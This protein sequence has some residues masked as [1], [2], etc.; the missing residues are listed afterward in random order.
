MRR[1]VGLLA[2][3]VFVPCI[4]GA[5]VTLDHCTPNPLDAMG[6]PQPMSVYGDGTFT[7]A[8]TETGGG[9]YFE[10]I[11][12]NTM[13]VLNQW[14]TSPNPTA[15]PP[16]PYSWMCAVI[17]GCPAGTWRFR[18][19]LFVITGSGRQGNVYSDLQ[20]RTISN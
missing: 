11:D 5:T 1:I 18:A 17:G 10:R 2:V 4:M 13:T 14:S 8:L 7:L 12:L 19:N 20:Q 6:K 15:P 3:M 9:V 16:P